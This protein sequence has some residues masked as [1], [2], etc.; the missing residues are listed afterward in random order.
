[1]AYE[2]PQDLFDALSAPFP[3]DAVEWRVGPTNER[4]RKEGELLKGQPLCYIDARA[5]MDRLD[6]VCGMDGWQCDYDF[7]HGGSVVCNLKLKMP[8]GEW[9]TKADGA[10]VTDME[11]EKG[12]LSDALKR[13]AVRFGLGRYLYD[14]KA[15]R[16]VLEQ[17]GK[18]A[19]IP[20]AE[21]KKLDEIYEA[22]ARKV[23][24]G[25]PSDVAVYKFLLN[26]VQETVTQPSDALA[27]R[28]KYKGMI[29]Q[30]RV[31]MRKHLEQIL[32]R[33]GEQEAA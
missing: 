11:A 8:S 23:G 28:E 18:S 13:A 10:G 27:F 31:A 20:D 3:P 4:Y 1:M 17:R 19:V 24:W 33:I 7:G 6:T 29:P 21:R 26:V 32:D 30:L 9:L 16:I 22:H 15:P 5:V 12:A 2:T 25:N 14:I